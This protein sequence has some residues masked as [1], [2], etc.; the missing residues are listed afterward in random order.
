MNLSRPFNKSFLA[1]VI[2][3][4]LVT[5]CTSMKNAELQALHATEQNNLL[6]QENDRL[7]ALLA[8]RSINNASLQMEL[9]KQQEEIARL[10]SGRQPSL[11]K[12]I[13]TNTIRT[14]AASTK[15]ETV[16]YLAEIETEIETFS[17]TSSPGQQE[18]VEKA[19]TLILE[20]NLELENG[21][22]EK[23]SL[24]AAQAMELI[25]TERVDTS[26]V[27]KR[28]SRHYTDFVSPLTLKLAKQSNIRA[29]PGKRSK[30]VTIVEK[31]SSVTAKGHQ[32]NWIKVVLP[33]GKSGWVYY[34]L[35]S[36]PAN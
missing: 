17:E 33:D 28:Y 32:G 20:S 21:N 24:L 18:A 35:L 31:G 15:V 26:S 6:Q 34:S 29:A 25:N 10:K 23:A 30:R 2:L 22:F 5:G 14:P 16:A 27:K 9:A 3:L 4:L 11:A 7:N 8:E 1:I 36:I 12:E 19:G 13:A